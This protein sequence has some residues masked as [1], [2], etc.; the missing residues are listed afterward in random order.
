MPIGI[1]S[2]KSL[3]KVN[4]FTKPHRTRVKVSS[5]A[6]MGP[7]HAPQELAAWREAPAHHS[8]R[9]SSDGMRLAE[10]TA[11]PPDASQTMRCHVSTGPNA[12]SPALS[13]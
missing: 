7:R 11:R 4:A 2:P 3:T 6:P 13:P 8:R 12:A 9:V 10:W 1:T 5:M